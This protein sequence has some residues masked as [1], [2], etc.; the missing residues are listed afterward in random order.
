[1]KNSGQNGDDNMQETATW[2]REDSEKDD[3]DEYV[4]ESVSESETFDDDFIELEYGEIEMGVNEDEGDDVQGENTGGLVVMGD[5]KAGSDYEDME[6]EEASL[7]DELKL[8]MKELKR[9]DRKKWAKKK[10]TF[11][12][13][14]SESDLRTLNLKVGQ[15]FGNT[16]V[17]KEAVK[18]HTIKQ[19][20]SIWFPCNEKSR[21]QGVCKCKLDNCSW[22]IWASC[23]AKNSP[24]LMIKTLND[25]HTCPRVQK[26][27][28]SNSTWL[29]KRYTEAL[30][31]EKEFKIFDF[32]GCRPIIRLDACHTKGNHKAQLMFAIGIDADNSYYPIAYAIVE[33]EC[34]MTWF[35]FLSLLKD[36]LKLDEDFRITFMTDKQKGLV[37]AIGEIWKNSEHRNCV[38]HLVKIMNRRAKRRIDLEKWYQNIGPRVAEF[39]EL[40]AQ[41]NGQFVAHWGGEGHYQINRG[42]I[43]YVVVDLDQRTCTCRRWNLTGIPCSHS[44]ATI[45]SKEDDPTKYV[46]KWYFKDTYKKCYSSVLHGIRTEELWFKTNMP[47]LLPL[48]DV[49]QAG[50]PR[51]LRIK[52][53]G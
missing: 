21:V 45:Y 48:K 10:P 35:W 9:M 2:S 16:K 3:E 15:V 24:A 4:T 18:E 38:R 41:H 22:L 8:A 31:P 46:D 14:N 32:L 6:Y 39:M 40:Q 49:K 26:N 20:R 11:E 44:M 34:Y 33:K 12:Q 42:S 37:E 52:E 7:D 5:E 47:L 43:A 13:F 1:M 51:K 28:L 27:Q 30:R 23:Y 50:R 19:G 29:A 25:K 53:I 36:D 17:F